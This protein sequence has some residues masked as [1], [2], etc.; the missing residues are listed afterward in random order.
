MAFT[1][2]IVAGP[3]AGAV[4]TLPRSGRFSIGSDPSCDLVLVDSTV[5]P[6]H[7]VLEAH[8]ASVTLEAVGPTFVNGLPLEKP[9]ADVGDT[10]DLGESVL[11]LRAADLSSA[12]EQVVVD[13]AMPVVVQRRVK[14]EELLENQ[15]HATEPVA[16]IEHLARIGTA[17]TTIDGLAGLGRPWLELVLEA[18]DAGCGALLLGNSDSLTGLCG[19]RRE[20]VGTAVHINRALVRTV[21][22]DSVAI[23][24][25]ARAAGASAGDGGW[26]VVTP[27][28]A[29]DRVLGALYVRRDG[30]RP[31]AIKDPL[32]FLTAVSAMAAVALAHARQLE[33]AET[34]S[35][36]QRAE[37]DHRHRMVGWS[38]AM[39]KVYRNIAKAAPTESTILITGDS[40]T[41]KE[42][43]ARAIHRNSRRADRPFAAINC[44][45]IPETLIESELFGHERGAFTGAVAQKRGRLELADGG[46]L[47]LDEIGELSL[48]V[49][50]KLLRVLEQR[51]VERVG[52]TRPLPLNFRLVAATNRDLQAAARAGQFRQDLFFRLN[53]VSLRIPPLRDRRDDIPVLAQY[54]AEIHARAAGFHAVSISPQALAALREYDWPGNVRELENVIERAIVL[55]A[56]AVVHLHDLPD[57]IGDAVALADEPAETFHAALRSRK[58]DLILRAVKRSGGNLAAAARGLDLHPNYL[59]RLIGTLQLRSLLPHKSSDSD[60]PPQPPHTDR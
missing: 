35:L 21:L 27:L 40:G 15:L 18:L 49:Q 29:F 59:H 26:I 45:A 36:Q 7:C 16:E 55:G 14:V 25:D 56:G 54:F 38:P 60:R 52:G 8:G 50:A 5:A 4:L 46:T 44:A 42:L 41:G 17:L 2:H 6:R 23:V 3:Q 31:P 24:A 33:R 43:V 32:P 51:E 13:D 58:K 22:E 1:L 28:R 53:V 37:H 47:F 34:E 19:V 10:I 20:A 12:G 48:S 9:A 39:R 57:L 30:A 11:V